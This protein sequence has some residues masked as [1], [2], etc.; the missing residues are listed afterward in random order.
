MDIITNIKNLVLDGRQITRGEA[1]SLYGGPLEELCAAADE[2]RKHFCGDL[3]D[4]CSIINAKSGRCTEDCKYCA[5]SSF[6]RTGT[7][8]YHLLDAKTI[9]S[10]AKYN[11]ERGGACR[12]IPLLLRG[13]TSRTMRSI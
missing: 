12:A 2:I 10:Q 1:A 6:Y 4:I 11:A 9:V 7:E 8:E 5:Q 13:K 3:F